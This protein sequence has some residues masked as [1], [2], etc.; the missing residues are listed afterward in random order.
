VKHSTSADAEWKAVNNFKNMTEKHAIFKSKD[1]V[2]KY[3]EV[4]TSEREVKSMLDLVQYLSENI[5]NTFLE[6]ACGTGNFLIEILR[7]RL[8]TVYR[9]HK[10]KQNN[11]DDIEFSI[12]RAVASIYGI[13]I[14]KENIDEARKKL[15]D[16]IKLFH[17]KK[18]KDK[19]PNEGFWDSVEWVLQ[20]NII[21]GD[22]LNKFEEI[23]LIEYGVPKPFYIKRREFTL[24]DGMKS[25]N[26]QTL[27]DF[28]RPLKSYKIT[29]YLKL[30]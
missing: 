20:N 28:G 23:S 5:H 16:E 15:F 9:K 29:H 11:Q 2:R 8:N 14:S 30:C 19:G 1:R 17:S 7:R 21:V 18:Y 6:P 24:A 26:S 25:K 27:F 12:V 13:D 10:N 4:F 3:A 22:F